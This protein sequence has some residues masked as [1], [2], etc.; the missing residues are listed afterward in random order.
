MAAKKQQLKASKAS[1]TAG[2][3]SKQQTQQPGE[4]AGS[5]VVQLTR[6]ES[7]SRSKEVE[8]WISRKAIEGDVG[9]T[10]MLLTSDR[11]NPTK[12]AKKKRRGLTCAQILALDPPWPGPPKQDAP[13]QTMKLG[14]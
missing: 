10:K 6:R 11:A 13:P 4:P 1:K 7:K 14:A 8:S 5:E 2:S 12:P 9:S 3:K